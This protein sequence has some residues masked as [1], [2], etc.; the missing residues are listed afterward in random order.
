MTLT[1]E[2]LAVIKEAL[3]L[4]ITSRHPLPNSMKE[5]REWAAVISELHTKITEAIKT[6]K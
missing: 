5:F 6:T 1:K 4:R 2:E 3:E